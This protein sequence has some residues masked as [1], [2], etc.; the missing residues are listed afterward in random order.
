MRS[1]CRSIGAGVRSAPKNIFYCIGDQIFSYIHGECKRLHNETLA[2]PVDDQPG[3]SVAFA[4]NNAAQPRIDAS[5][6]AVLPGLGDSALE[7]IQVQIL[8]PPAKT[9][10]LHSV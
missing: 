6:G 3:Q 8:F 7:E 10:G 2:V 1:A 9:G 5:P 4:P